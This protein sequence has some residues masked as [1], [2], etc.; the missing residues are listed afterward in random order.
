MTKERIVLY[1]PSYGNFI[2]LGR[3]VTEASKKCLKNIALA[4]RE[5]KIDKTEIKKEL[6]YATNLIKKKVTR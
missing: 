1:H 3:T 6:K 5:K 2:G 4:L